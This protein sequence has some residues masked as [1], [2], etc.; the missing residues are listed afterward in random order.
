[1]S[2]NLVAKQVKPGPPA[3]E[4]T[5]TV[6]FSGTYTLNGTGDNIDFTATLN[7]DGSARNPAFLAG[8]APIRLPL[9]WEENG[10]DMAGAYVEI[11]P[12]ADLKTWKVR[13]YAANG[14]ELATNAAYP[15]GAPL[16]AATSN[17]QLTVGGLSNLT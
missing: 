15:A 14:T 17:L 4:I 11:T 12:G 13:F 9:N 1:M 16:S 10:G 7:P 8:A 2:I 6:Y 5:F 3:K